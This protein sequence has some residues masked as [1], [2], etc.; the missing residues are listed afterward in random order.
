[1]EKENKT[2]D[3]P[4]Y[5]REYMKKRYL[6]NKEQGQN[7]SKAYYYIARGDATKEEQKT[8]GE[9]LPYIVKA[10]KAL[11]LLKS[12]NAV[13]FKELLESYKIENL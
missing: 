7:I 3:R 8:Y 13:F 2:K 10:K 5:Q 12:K 1:M 6:E 11:E 9:N 4:K